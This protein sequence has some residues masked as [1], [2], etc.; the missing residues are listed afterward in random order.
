MHTVWLGWTSDQQV[1]EA[2]ICTKSY[3]KYKRRTF[4]PSV[5]FETSIPAS[6]QLQAYVFDRPA[7][8]IGFYQELLN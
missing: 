1:A 8:G 6:K 4:M 3:N 7:S 5:G 2:A